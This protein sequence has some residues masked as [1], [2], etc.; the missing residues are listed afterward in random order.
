[1]VHPQ[2]QQQQRFLHILYNIITTVQN[3]L[4]LIFVYISL[5]HDIKHTKKTFSIMI[6]NIV[7]SVS[8]NSLALISSPGWHLHCSN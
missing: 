1:M 5:Y 6:P 2:Q 8:S 3:I 7:I 4:Q